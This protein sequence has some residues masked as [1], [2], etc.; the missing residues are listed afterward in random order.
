MNPA[1]PKRCQNVYELLRLRGWSSN[2]DLQTM[3]GASSADR[4]LRELR[5]MYPGLIEDRVRKGRSGVLYKE[6]RINPFY[7]ATQPGQTVMM[8]LDDRRMPTEGG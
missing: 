8:D 2:I 5:E 1:I 6:Y 4:K 3:T 7:G